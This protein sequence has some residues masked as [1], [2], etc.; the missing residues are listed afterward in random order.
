MKDRNGEFY[1]SLDREIDA[2]SHQLD[3]GVE[4]VE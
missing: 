2:S 1:C 4:T 3:L